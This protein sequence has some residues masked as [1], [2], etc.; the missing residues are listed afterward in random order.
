MP[1][2]DPGGNFASSGGYGQ[3]NQGGGGFQPGG[4]LSGGGTSNQTGNW[5]PS[6]SAGG[7][8]GY[9]SGAPGTFGGLGLEQ[10]SWGNSQPGAGPIKVSPQVLPKPQVV[11]GVTSPYANW[12]DSWIGSAQPVWDPHYGTIGGPTSPMVGSGTWGVG[13]LVPSAPGSGYPHPGYTG[14]GG[15]ID[16][17][18]TGP[19]VPGGLPGGQTSGSGAQSMN[20]M[21]AQPPSQQPQVSPGPLGGLQPQQMK[22]MFDLMRMHRGLSQ[23]QTQQGQTQPARMTLADWM[24]RRQGAQQPPQGPGTMMPP[25]VGPGMPSGPGNQWGF[26]GSGLGVSGLMPQ[27]RQRFGLAA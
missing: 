4:A 21:A 17:G 13:G 26:G 8:F 1:F 11:P 2:G 6:A 22:T 24:A 7:I 14:P 18:T 27:M 19:S 23:D 15:P 12:A 20:M 5:N 9:H 16:M 3:F 10:T 25:Q